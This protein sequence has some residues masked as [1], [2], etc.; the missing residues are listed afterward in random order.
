MMSVQSKAA[1]GSSPSEGAGSDKEVTPQHR[2]VLI[3]DDDEMVRRV[4]A[5]MLSGADVLMASSGAEACRVLAE[6]GD[7]PV[8]CVLLDMRMPG[9][10]FEEAFEGIREIRPNLPVVACSGNGP[11]AVGRDFIETPGTGFLGKPFTRQELRD[12]IDRAIGEF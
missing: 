4:S 10:T 11:E 12:A 3:V 1:S 9:L 6:R 7:D 5:R 2:S 8:D